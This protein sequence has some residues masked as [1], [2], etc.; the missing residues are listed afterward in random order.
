MRKKVIHLR[1]KKSLNEM[2]TKVVCSS[3]LQLNKKDVEHLMKMYFQI[4]VKNKEML[5]LLTTQNPIFSL[6]PTLE[7]LRASYKIRSS[8]TRL[9]DH[10]SKPFSFTYADAYLEPYVV[11]LSC[12]TETAKGN[13]KKKVLRYVRSLLQTKGPVSTQNIKEEWKYSCW[14]RQH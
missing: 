9:Q 11:Y 5:N 14:L 7:G 10:Y 8:G 2:R 6:R 13:E 1:D 12:S 4:D 3:E